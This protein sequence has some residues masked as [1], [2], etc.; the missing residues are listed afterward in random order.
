MVVPHSYEGR[1][2][3][4]REV[5]DLL[6]VGFCW[7]YR[8]GQDHHLHSY[9]DLFRPTDI[10]VCKDRSRLGSRFHNWCYRCVAGYPSVY[11]TEKDRERDVDAPITFL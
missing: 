1:R 3:V 6:E 11:L 8:K 5:K 9:D 4:N 10:P 7:D 2:Y